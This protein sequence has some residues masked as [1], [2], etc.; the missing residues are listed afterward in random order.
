MLNTEIKNRQLRT[1]NY[2]ILCLTS[3]PLHLLNSENIVVS[4]NKY[5]L[6]HFRA[7][8]KN[9]LGEHTNLI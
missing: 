1:S 4:P 7:Q 3:K 6:W 5:L 8:I 9:I 2:T